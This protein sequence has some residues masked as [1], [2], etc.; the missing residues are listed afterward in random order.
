MCTKGAETSAKNVEAFAA[1][2]VTLGSARSV[3]Y[4]ATSRLRAQK[5]TEREQHRVKWI[6]SSSRHLVNDD[7]LLEDPKEY[8]CECVAA[9]GGYLRIN[10]RGSV[11]ITTTIMEK[12]SKNGDVTV[13]GIYVDDLLV[14]A[15]NPEMDLGEVR[16]FLGMR[17]NLD[18]AE[19][20][21]LYQQA[22]IEEMVTQHGLMEANGVRAPGLLGS[23]SARGK[24]ECHYRRWRPSLLLPRT[25]HENYWV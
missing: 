2:V 13:V 20:Y 22:A 21:P 14:T 8:V 19:T 4:L 6:S 16:K 25:S 24:R 10:K 3:E 11:T 5:E 17:V 15:S 18:N 7:K 23:G 9:N 1:N 12:T